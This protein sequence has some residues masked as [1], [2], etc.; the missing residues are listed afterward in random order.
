MH[1][2]KNKSMH[3]FIIQSLTCGVLRTGV[4]C[5]GEL[6][7]AT[8]LIGVPMDAPSMNAPPSLEGGVSA[9]TCAHHRH[10]HNTWVLLNTVGWLRGGFSNLD[11]K[12]EETNTDKHNKLS[13]LFCRI[14][15]TDRL[16]ETSTAFH[17]NL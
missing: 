13:S 4:R 1:S 12:A 3:S 15:Y 2:D 8:M 7:G 14:P 5:M 17:D 16:S 6:A 11:T 9:S 10:R